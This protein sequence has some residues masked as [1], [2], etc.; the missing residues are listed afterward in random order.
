MTA[1]TAVRGG[2]NPQGVIP[3]EMDKRP[4]TDR[5]SRC[6]A[7]LQ[8]KG[9]VKTQGGYGSQRVGSF[10]KG[11]LCPKQGGAETQKDSRSCPSALPNHHYPNKGSCQ[12]NISPLLSSTMARWQPSSPSIFSIV[13]SLGSSGLYSQLLKFFGLIPSRSASSLDFRFWSII[14]CLIAF[15]TSNIS[16]PLSSRRL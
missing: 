10:C 9:G 2:V 4:P 11:H 15:L 13:P 12:N 7:V 8:S 1:Y 14:K 5:T 3:Q 16:I 6:G